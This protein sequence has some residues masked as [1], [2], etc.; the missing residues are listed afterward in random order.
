[1]AKDKLFV[2]ISN[3]D[4]APMLSLNLEALSSKVAEVEEMSITPRTFISR[5]FNAGILNQDPN[6][7]TDLD[8]YWFIDEYQYQQG[9]PVMRFGIDRGNMQ[10][11][12]DELL[13]ERVKVFSSWQALEF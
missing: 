6:K 3:T 13:G 10:L 11:R 4:T 7:Q 8:D 5:T 1:M 9:A 12:G 2:K